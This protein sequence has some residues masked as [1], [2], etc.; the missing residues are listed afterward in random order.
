MLYAT[1]AQVIAQE[2]NSG[3]LSDLYSRQTY[4]IAKFEFNVTVN[5]NLLA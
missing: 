1:A 3:S 4:K 5:Y 2:Y